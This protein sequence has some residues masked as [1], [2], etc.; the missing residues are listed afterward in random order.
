MLDQLKLNTVRT[1]GNTSTIEIEPLPQ[2]YG[3]TLGNSLRRVLLSSMEGG[4]IIQVKIAGVMH[5]YS[6]I[7]G[8]KEDVVHVLLN[9]KRVKLQIHDDKEV[10]LSLDVSGAK[11]VTAKDIKVGPNV[12]IVN[13]D[14]VI[15]TL[16][17]SKAKISMEMVAKT[18][19]GYEGVENRKSTSIGAI[20]L[21]ATFSPVLM[22]NYKVSET[23]VGQMTNLDKLTMDITT[24]GSV[25]GEE[26]IK[27]SAK[28]LVDYFNALIEPPKEVEPAKETSKPSIDKNALVEELELSTRIT[29]ALKGAGINNIDDLL[30]FPKGEILRLKNLG[31]KSLSDIEERL[32]EKGLIYG[33]PVE[34][35]IED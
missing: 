23:R 24:D 26:A 32:A 5:E 22:V 33:A 12:E 10:N 11:T 21:D 25:S 4:S 14:Q 35:D 17:D 31:A 19:V 8:I 15:A 27:K 2:G 13:P 1:S 7:K 16:T 6:T 18:G 29:N 34:E 28:I 3:M 20:P 30:N 9:L